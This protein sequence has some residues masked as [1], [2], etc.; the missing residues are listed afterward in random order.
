[1]HHL[2]PI[3][4]MGDV[5]EEIRQHIAPQPRTP[6]TDGVRTN[7]HAA[8]NALQT[9][10]FAALAE[11]TG[12]IDAWLLG[13][14]AGGEITARF[15]YRALRKRLVQAQRRIDKNLLKQ[16]ADLE[17]QNITSKKGSRKK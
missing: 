3:S 11:A 16:E 2:E 1:M 17:K 14:S 4:A 12:S 6:A 15:K 8:G 9:L 5:L 7:I 10:D 13:A